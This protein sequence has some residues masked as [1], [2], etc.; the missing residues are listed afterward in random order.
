MV[1]NDKRQQIMS[2]V[3]KVANSRRFHEVTLDEIARGAKVGKG[4]IYHYFKDKEDLFFQ[5]ATS[6]FDE[7]CELLKQKIPHNTSFSEKLLSICK[8]VSRF[9]SARHQLLQMMQTE[10]GLVYWRGGRIRQR[11]LDKRKVLVDTLADVFAEGVDAGV[12]RSD[13]STEIL[14]TFLLGLLRTRARDLR[15][16]PEN[17]KSYTLLVDLFMNG[18]GV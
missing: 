17:M 16:T 10:A 15:D 18:A 14:A 2:V 6:G 5:V 4:T 1:H 9:F 12:I 13:I 7:L 3:E 8:H 11:W